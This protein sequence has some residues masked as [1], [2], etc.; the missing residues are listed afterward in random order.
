MSVVFC[1]II[2]VMC[3]CNFAARN[4]SEY[5]EVT[6]TFVFLALKHIWKRWICYI[7]YSLLI[8]DCTNHR[9]V[10]ERWVSQQ[11]VNLEL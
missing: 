10:V 8:T 2:S 9:F 3:T 1:T 4:P 7:C 11:A 5:F 6:A